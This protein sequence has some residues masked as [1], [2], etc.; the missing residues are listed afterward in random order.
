[1]ER[2][3]PARGLLLPLL[4]LGGLSLLA[5]RGADTSMEACC[6]EGRQKATQ[7]KDCSSPYTSGSQE[8]RMVQ[9]ECCDSQLEELHC[10]TGIN[11]AKEQ[12]SCAAP[13]AN[14][15][16]LALMFVKRCCQCCLLGRAAQGQGQ[17]C[18]NSLTMG[19][20][21]G[22]VFRA[23]CVKGQETANLTAGDVGGPQEKPKKKGEE[24]QEDPYLN[25][26]C[27]GGGPCKQ[28]C[29]D[30][31]DK[32]VCSCFVGYQLLP[33]GVSC[34]D[35]NECIAGR[36]SC[37]VGETCIN[38]VGSFRCQ[39]E[40]SCGTGYELTESNDC[41]DIDEC[42]SGIHNCL[43]D[44]ICQ[45]TL[46][47]FRCRP[48]L[49]CK[50]GF[51]QDALGNCIDINECLTLGAPCPAGQTCINTEGSYTCRKNVPNCGRGYHLNKEGKQCVDVDECLPPSEPC[52]AGHVC[53]NSPGSYRCEC[54][55]G[56]YFNSVTRTC[57]DVNECQHYPAR[58][59][60]HKCENVPGSY[61]CT[62]TKGFRLTSDGRTC[63]DVNEC[64]SNPC[65]QEC[66]NIYG[67]FQCYCRRGYKL[68]DVDGLTCE[69]IDECSLPTGGHICAYR[70]LNTVGSFQCSCPQPGYKL[71]PNGR[72][73]QDINECVAG[74]HN[75]TINETCF[76]IQGGFRCLAFQCPEN[77]RR[78]ADTIQLPPL[79]LPPGRIGCACRSG[80]VK[81]DAFLCVKSCRQDDTACMLNPVHTVSHSAISLPTIRHFNQPDEIVFLRTMMP[82]YPAP[83]PNVIFDIKE[84]NLRHSF[85]IVKRY[86]DGAVVGIVRQVRPIVGP[87]HT[88]LKLEMNFVNGGVVSHRNEVN[89][90]IF[91]SEYWF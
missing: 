19:H 25:D 82:A 70:C 9:E 84:G 8:C 40:S 73:C 60:T 2:A 72:N 44:F 37:R 57:V 45:N 56:Y 30:T 67:S 79:K 26:R 21:C 90:H 49:Q 34:E 32:V 86:V 17:S 55:P 65:S 39:R 31:G 87:F 88:V 61:H 48:K 69:D 68:S 64:H 62:C 50:S 16:G 33:D 1:M 43:P 41:K 58:L 5:A 15:T 71:A 14:A 80:Q 12:E 20:R 76:N 10:T 74:I 75:C 83:Q 91:I 35:V 18:E 78:S 27:R 81:V 3:A 89:V 11:L 6:A 52:G 38:T 36:H 59:C 46:G 66:T 4:L 54:K 42:E 13:S 53:I 63:E 7:Q 29:R 22:Q 23:C 51:I 47:S 24:E 77:Y 28:Q 85:D